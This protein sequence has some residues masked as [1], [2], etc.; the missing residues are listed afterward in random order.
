MFIKP[1]MKILCGFFFN[2]LWLLQFSTSIMCRKMEYFCNKS[3]NWGQ[4]SSNSERSKIS[5]LKIRLIYK[6]QTLKLKRKL[7]LNESIDLFGFSLAFNDSSL[8]YS[9]GIQFWPPRKGLKHIKCSLWPHYLYC[10][11]IFS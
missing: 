7:K 1:C 6:R 3:I 4:R 8:V 11:S 9:L 5:E 2:F 10:N